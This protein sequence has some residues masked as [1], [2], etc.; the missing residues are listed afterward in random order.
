MSDLRHLLTS[1]A[2]K[3]EPMKKPPVKVDKNSCLR[4]RKDSASPKCYSDSQMN[5]NA[6]TTVEE[7]LEL[8]PSVISIFVGRK[9]K[10]VGCPASAY[11]TLEEVSCFYN[12]SVDDFLD[13]IHTAIQNL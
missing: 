13:A 1:G 5:V 3:H 12:L 4:W 6:K 7:L 2:Q 10:C 9:M 8:Y 11:H